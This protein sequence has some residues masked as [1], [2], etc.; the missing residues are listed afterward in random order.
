MHEQCDLIAGGA[1]DGLDLDQRSD[2]CVSNIQIRSE[3]FGPDA[4]RKAISEFGP[5]F[6]YPYF[7]GFGSD[8]MCNRS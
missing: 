8:A 4:V 7:L 3:S 6:L 5:N 2:E 1:W